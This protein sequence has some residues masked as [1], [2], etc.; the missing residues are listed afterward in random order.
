MGYDHF[1]PAPSRC[2]F[3]AHIQGRGHALRG[4]SANRKSPNGISVF[5]A[6]LVGR[7]KSNGP[8]GE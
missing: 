4:E 1:R 5:V 6:Q 2:S 7:P 3:Y 8:D